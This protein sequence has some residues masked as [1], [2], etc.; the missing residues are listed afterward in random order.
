MPDASAPESLD[1]IAQRLYHTNGLATYW[2][3]FEGEKLQVAMTG[4]IKSEHLSPEQFALVLNYCRYWFTAPCWRANITR[5]F[6]DRPIRTKRQALDWIYE[7]INRW[8]IDP[9]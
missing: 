2:K 6:I 1:S 8:A 7:A 5:E 3:D 4:F 9:L